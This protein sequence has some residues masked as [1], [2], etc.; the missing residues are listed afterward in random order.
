MTKS[1]KS[2]VFQSVIAVAMGII[3]GGLL[4]LQLHWAWPLGIA[5]GG[6]I[7]LLFSDVTWLRELWKRGAVALSNEEDATVRT[8]KFMLYYCSV[9]QTLALVCCL[10]FGIN[11]LLL[12]DLNYALCLV[13]V[14]EVLYALAL[15]ILFIIVVADDISKRELE[16]AKIT[17]DQFNLVAIAI[18]AYTYSVKYSVYAWSQLIAGA[19][20]CK[21]AT[22][23]YLLN[24]S[25]LIKENWPQIVQA[26][27][28]NRITCLVTATFGALVG[29]LLGNVI[30]GALIGVALYLFDRRLTNS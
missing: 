1:T 19:R 16:Q 25:S 23:Y 24:G 3:I 9:W 4:A 17:Y 15:L 27:R 29:F 22:H 20:R 8:I 10:V 7:G 26:T 14:I 21:T 13:F 5:V 18:P 2:Q 11:S 6:F 28:Q 12:F 30:V